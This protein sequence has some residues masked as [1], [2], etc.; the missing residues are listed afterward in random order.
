MSTRA[1]VRAGEPDA[2]RELFDEHARSVYNH[3]VRLTG[4]WSVAE[5]VVSLTFRSK[6]CRSSRPR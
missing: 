1:R 6:R 4:D 3:G 5:E 2:F